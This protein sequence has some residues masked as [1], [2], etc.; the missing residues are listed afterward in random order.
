MFFIALWSSSM[1]I[2]IISWFFL[3][4][5]YFILH[6]KVRHVSHLTINYLENSRHIW[7]R[8][9]GKFGFKLFGWDVVTVIL[10]FS[11]KPWLT[12]FYCTCC[13]FELL[14]LVWN[15][16]VTNCS[17]GIKIY[18]KMT[19]FFVEFVILQIS[20][21][22]NGNLNTAR[23]IIWNTSVAPLYNLVQ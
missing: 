7:M 22:C 21:Q 17:K 5:F 18:L 3:Q 14:R 6:K 19:S 2:P 16:L 23:L 1:L 9:F 15:E 12:T 11:T 13:C 4:F 8:G 20:K 10:I